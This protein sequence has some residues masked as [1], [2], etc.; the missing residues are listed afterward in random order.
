MD[1]KKNF[2]VIISALMLGLSQPG[3]CAG[4]AD[5]LDPNLLDAVSAMETEAQG[6][7][8]PVAEQV[9]VEEQKPELASDAGLQP[10]PRKSITARFNG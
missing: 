6:V 2:V 10:P 5:N 9:K 4:L 7:V 1:R 3:I 8:V